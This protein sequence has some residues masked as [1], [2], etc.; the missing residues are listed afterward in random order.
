MSSLF[1]SAKEPSQQTN[2]GSNSQSQT[3]GII[4][5]FA[6][7]PFLNAIRFRIEQMVQNKND[8]NQ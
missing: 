5:K 2:I 4:P 3:S 7:N 8:S 6:Q 1:E